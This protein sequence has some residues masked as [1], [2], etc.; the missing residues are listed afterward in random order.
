MNID[1]EVCG[2]NGHGLLGVLGVRVGLGGGHGG[3]CG[4]TLGLFI[5]L[6]TMYSKI[7]FLNGCF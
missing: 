1:I 5:F 7:G 3:N 6:I 2:G 4:A